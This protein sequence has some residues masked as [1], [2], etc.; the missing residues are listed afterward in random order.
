MQIIH[1]DLSSEKKNEARERDKVTI[2]AESTQSIYQTLLGLAKLSADKTFLWL[3][4]V[5]KA[6]GR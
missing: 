3:D 4:T 2:D 6:E 5:L 1:L